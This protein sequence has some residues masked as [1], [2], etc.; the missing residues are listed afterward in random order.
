MTRVI[1]E[2]GSTFYD[3]DPDVALANA[4]DA[5]DIAHI[6]GADGVKFQLFQAD[7]LYSQVRA[8]EIYKNI[9]KY[10]LPVKWLYVLQKRAYALRLQFGVS[11]FSEELAN[12]ALENADHL[13][14]IKLASGDLTND[15]LLRHACDLVSFNRHIELPISTGA[16]SLSEVNHAM[17]IIEEYDLASLVMFHCVSAYPA[18]K[19]DANL[20]SV[21]SFSYRF[22]DYGYG[23]IGLSD[24]TKDSTV[25]QIAVGAGYDVFEKHV[26]LSGNVKTPDDVVAIDKKQFSTYV[27]NIRLAEKIMGDRVKKPQESETNE[28][29]WARRGKDGLRPAND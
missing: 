14:F 9:A 3:P 5:I 21:H 23:T 13:S 22:L 27:E 25:A 16:A 6:C 12:L 17:D 2:I 10:E 20:R 7:T 15:R 1:A 18:K 11:V 24:H 26:N 4:L 29:I 28:R 8:P 19:T